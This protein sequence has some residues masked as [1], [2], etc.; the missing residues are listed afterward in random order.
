MAFTIEAR[1]GRPLAAEEYL[2]TLNRDIDS[3][4]DIEAILA[5]APQLASLCANDD[6]I[7]EALN[8][9]LGKWR[10]FQNGNHYSAQTF[11]L[12]VSKK[13]VIRA[14]V[15]MPPSGD[16]SAREWEDKFYYYRVPHDHNFSFMTCGYFGSGYATT[17]YEYEHDEVTGTPGE[18]V[19]MRFLERTTL[20]KGKVMFYRASRD[21][22]SQEHPEEF[23]I[24]VNL[25]VVNPKETL[26]TQYQF[27]L[28]TGAVQGPIE[29]TG[30]AQRMLTRTAKYLAN[31]R[32]RYLLD[33]LSLSHPNPRFRASCYDSLVDL[34]PARVE[35]LI[36][37]AE[38]DAHPF[39]REFARA[40]AAGGAERAALLS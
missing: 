23:S 26:R 4:D 13:F 39:V 6:L 7:V 15:W 20:P 12:G 32:T 8:K 17:I 5:S 16:S 38:S 2:E 40:A 30:A 37:R 11:I 25:L 24:S 34:E 19:P 9:E 29:N 22:H 27:D 3:T 21:I 31:D 14:N 36:C 18:R 10:E 35:D 1:A 28:E 33:D